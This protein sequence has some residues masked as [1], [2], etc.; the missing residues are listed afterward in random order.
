M[1]GN[2]VEFGRFM[3]RSSMRVT[4]WKREDRL[5][6]REDG[7]VDFAASKAKIEATSTAPERLGAHHPDRAGTR[8]QKDRLEIA[9]MQLDLDERAGL[10]TPT[11]DVAAAASAAGA[12]IRSRAENMP[13]ILSPQLAAAVGGDEERCRAIL[14]AW[15]EQFLS[16]CS[17]AMYCIAAGTKAK[18]R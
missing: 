18:R 3:G 6:F 5:V 9:R 12:V 17:T 14:T 13:Y 8:I 1:Y 15:V 16:E 10:L 4:E 11:A 2:Q 7:K